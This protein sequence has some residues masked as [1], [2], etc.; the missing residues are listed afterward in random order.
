M[1]LFAII[2]FFVA[3][4][5]GITIHE[6]AHAWTANKLGDSTAK[7]LGRISLNP[8]RHI[9]LVGTILLPII[10]LLSPAHAFFG[11]AKPTPYNPRNLK[12][13]HKDEILLAIAG[14][15]SNILLAGLLVMFFYASAFGG[16]LLMY[17]TH[18]TM[19][20]PMIINLCNFFY[21]AVYENLLLAFFNLL[22]VPPLD[23]SSILKSILPKQFNPLIAFLNQFG[24]LLLIIITRIPELDFVN[25]YLDA[26]VNYCLRLVGLS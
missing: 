8:L 14:P 1:D 21:M 6:S 26:C 13:G 24:Y 15:I 9:D 3:F 17:F 7:D 19:F 18:N 20:R 5:L 2:S 4:L 25:P 23:G 16:G 11:W 10:G 12:D 22:P